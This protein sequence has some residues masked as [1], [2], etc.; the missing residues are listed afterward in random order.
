MKTNTLR[1]TYGSHETPTKV[2]TLTTGHGW[3]GVT[4]YVCHDSLNV[5]ATL[6]TL[7]DGVNV[8]L[9]GDVDCIT[10]QEPITSESELYDLLND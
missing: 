5:N 10:P 9:V 6:E 8:E 4:W 7:D 1:G 3:H 2:Y